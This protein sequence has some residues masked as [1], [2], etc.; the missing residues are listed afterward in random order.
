MTAWVRI[1]LKELSKM[2]SKIM[3]SECYDLFW[4]FNYSLCRHTWKFEN[5]VEYLYVIN[6]QCTCFLL[7]ITSRRFLGSLIL[8]L[9]YKF[10]L[11]GKCRILDND[12]NQSVA[13]LQPEE[14]K[15]KKKKKRTNDE[16]DMN[17]EKP[18]L[19]K[20]IKNGSAM[21]TENSSAEGQLSQV[22][23]LPNGLVIQELETGKPNGKV[24]A[25]GKK[26]S[27]LESVLLVK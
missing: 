4:D 15:K 11:C 17:M 16:K 10:T 1:C 23:T 6:L 26:V 25:S 2:R 21:D 8:I 5:V 22:S 20:D 13:E 27:P 14:K 18:I 12:L 7:C 24:A 19:S 9:V 3:I